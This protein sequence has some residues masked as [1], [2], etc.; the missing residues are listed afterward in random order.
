MIKDIVYNVFSNDKVMVINSLC[1]WF[2]LYFVV[3]SPL[4]DSQGDKS[5]QTDACSEDISLEHRHFVLFMSL[6]SSEPAT[7][8]SIT[9]VLQFLMHSLESLSPSD[10]ISSAFMS[11]KNRIQAENSTQM[12]VWYSTLI[13]KLCV[14]KDFNPDRF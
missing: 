11:A 7:T 1:I 12:P 10:C 13:K 6:T 9:T 4:E 5:K 14:G 2:I 3:E 8:C